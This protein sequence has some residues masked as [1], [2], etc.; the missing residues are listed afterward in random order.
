M[1]TYQRNIEALDNL[2]QV[3]KKICKVEVTLKKKYLRNKR[4]TD[5]LINLMDD[6]MEKYHS[7][8]KNLDSITFEKK[9]NIIKP[10]VV[11]ITNPNK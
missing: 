2:R 3:N 9:T 8:V 10:S 6:S 4:V 11:Q 7:I 1:K 5:D